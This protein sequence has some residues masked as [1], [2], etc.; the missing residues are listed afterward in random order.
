MADSEKGG[1]F[2]AG[3]NDFLA[4]LLDSTNLVVYLKDIAGRYIYVNQRYEALA[5]VPRAA[6]LGK[7][8]PDFFPDEVA[9]IFKAQ[10]AQVI[11][12][13]HA[14]EF[15][16]TIPLPGGVH[17]FVTQ[18]FPL[19]NEKGEV[20]AVGG[21]CTEIS[22]QKNIAETSLA[23]AHKQ[24]EE[25]LRRKEADVQVTLESLQVGVVTHAA[26][27][28]IIASNPEAQRILGLTHE[29]LSGK[30]VIDPAWSFVY[31]D[32]GRM[33]V[34]DFP[35]SKAISSGKPVVGYTLGIQRP[36][37]DFI[38]WVI[39]NASPL[40][41]EDGRLERVVVNF[42]DI[43]ERKKAEE[44]VLESTALLESVVEN[45][46]Q[47]IFLKE[48]K[49]LRF[50]IFNR[51]GEELLGHDK[52]TLLG[53]NNL[54]LF[55]PEQAAQFM[56]ADRAVL[57]GEAGYLDIPEEPISTSKKGLRV[58][59]TRKVR[60]MGGDGATKYLLGISEDITD[61]KREASVLQKTKAMMQAA[62]AS[63]ADAVFVSNIGAD[64]I[65]FNEAFATFHK[66]KDINEC[67]KNLADFHK[68]LD[69]FMPDGTLVPHDMWVVARALRGET[70][71][72]AEYKLRRKDTGET[73]I[74]SYNFA[75]IRD[76][77]GGI[78]GSVVVARDIT[79]SK[80]AEEALKA[81]QHMLRE[82]EQIGKVGGW[83][84]NIDTMKQVWTE[85]VYRIH[86]V[87]IT[88]D[89]TV[90]KGINYYTPES[91]PVIER[92]VQR[93]IEHAEGFNLELEIIT[94]KGNRRAVHTIGKADLK[95]RKIDG[96]F[97][98]ITERK[99][100]EVRLKASEER[101]KSLMQQSP[102]VVELYNL[103]G[104][105][106][107]VNKAYE[108]LWG[109]PAERTVNK[110][111]VLK[112]KEVEDTG[113]M[114]YVKRAYA[115]DSV[116]VPEYRYNPIGDTEAKGVGRIRWLSTRIYPLK[117]ESGKV[118]NIVI[119]HQDITERKQAET[120]L[121]DSEALH[122]AMTENISDV[123]AI[124][125]ADGLIKFKSQNIQRWFGWQP[126]DLVGREA[127]VTVH[128]EDIGLVQKAFM[129]VLGQ[130]KA[131][132][133]VEY[134]YRCKDGS[135]LPI[136]LT[137]VNLISD[138]AICGVLANYHDISQRKAAEQALLESEERYRKLVE[139][140]GKEYFF[141][142]HDAAGVFNYISPSLTAMLGYSLEEF[143]AHYSEHL[144]DN[145]VNKEAERHTSLS[146]QG[147]KQ[148]P[149]QVEIFHKDGSRRWLEVEE[150]PQ[151]GPDGK[152]SGVEG[153][154][155][156][157][158]ARLQAQKEREDM[159]GQLLQSQ[160]MESVGRLAGGVAH[161]FNNLLTAIGAYAG[162]LHKG[163]DEGDALMDDVK[164]IIAATERAAALTR[165]LLA[166]SRKQILSPQIF[167]LNASLG[168]TVKMLQRLIGEDIKLETR[169]AARECHVKMDPG[170][171]DQLLMNLAVNA[172]DAMPKGGMLVIKTS[173]E[174][175]GD[176][177]LV[178]HPDLASGPLVRLSV[179]DN[180]EGMSPQVKE[181]LF[182]PF[183][184]T[185]GKGQ[186]TGLGLATVF[187][188]VKQSGGE[189]EVESVE[190]QGTTF[191]VYLPLVQA[192]VTAKPA[193]PAADAEKLIGKGETVLL[194]EDEESLRRLGERVLKAA[195]FAVTVA[196]HGQAA[197]AAAEK[198]GKPFD[199][200]MT[201]VV[202]PGMSGRELAE[203]LSR[204]KLVGRVLYMSGYTD[205]A[206]VRH[207][208]LEQGIAFIYK[209]FTVDNLVAKLREVLDGPAD[210]AKA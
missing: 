144:T 93:A 12:C 8:D 16:E 17:S 71:V 68:I 207:G 202:M 114:A 72:N 51:A 172:R 5:G 84:F 121:C 153:I 3:H 9:D 22:A 158:T 40:F 18:K 32:L 29:Q 4:G 103:D 119:V 31:E 59:H 127:W 177:F 123:I 45:A 87:D 188:I 76:E 139:N 47:M 187:G 83:S 194:V 182:E 140:V 50:V 26:D 205:D 109:F 126:Q 163:L 161:D 191:T 70:G 151:F 86:E 15:E 37:R 141:Y 89:P 125:G 46:P 122:R 23:D 135:F 164:E 165:Q 137:A 82:T 159:Q 38:T 43:T 77:N 6:L 145:P 65:Q 192:P 134:R 150:I 176:D 169:M 96:F 73:W 167:D 14:M 64:F 131:V 113:L 104:L 35:V 56:A 112:S 33:K 115:G 62:L 58:L 120:A 108:E 28:H 52:K 110:F 147:E 143:L 90:E 206:I 92:A 105:Q 19:L 208:V 48:A 102:F 157:I 97:Q 85:E 10:D 80:Q 94:A 67:G 133:T 95:N 39:V 111:N 24:A 21:F 60:I 128:P 181:H 54:D 130:D 69:V 74:G 174:T 173:V 100:A 198:H 30:S 209:P 189:I 203:E 149:Y 91:R 162:F 57:D 178:M 148:P 204:R 183:F 193:S 171:M 36:D 196:E 117:N 2:K 20:W 79:A 175:P 200:L 55:P 190:G 99:A 155:H 201:D 160:K 106:V 25:E 88:P 7:R 1:E 166:F 118:E 13:R 129:D 180:G 53:K 75:P 101:F 81:S 34:E 63:M 197:L 199:V 78:I 152:V 156:D 186:G 42:V 41:A 184:T 61:R 210:Q 179:A 44:K 98:D 195:G 185:K 27:T 170:Q 132:V 49:D 124:I 142:Q 11:A 146:L 136:T 168:S 107:S 154:A 116:V 138:P 66:F